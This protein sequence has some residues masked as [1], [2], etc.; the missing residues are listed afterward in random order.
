MHSRRLSK[1]TKKPSS[2]L[3]IQRTG[4]GASKEDKRER[5]REREDVGC[6]KFY[7]GLPKAC[8]TR[9]REGG[10]RERKGKGQYP[11]V[12]SAMVGI[13][14]SKEM[15][16]LPVPISVEEKNRVDLMAGLSSFSYSFCSVSMVMSNKVWRM[17]VASYCI[18]HHLSPCASFEPFFFF[19]PR[20]RQA[21]GGGLVYPRRQSKDCLVHAVLSFSYVFTAIESLRSLSH[22]PLSLH[23]PLIKFIFGGRTDVYSCVGQKSVTGCLVVF[24]NRVYVKAR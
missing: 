8:V 6:E 10:E 9:R 7:W 3:S 20:R 13:T 18:V 11:V 21:G 24:P 2:K 14:N 19:A 17:E 5:E 22:S 4:L 12:V 23:L 16:S 1:T 15:S